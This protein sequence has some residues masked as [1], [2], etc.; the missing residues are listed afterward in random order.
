MK[1]SKLQKLPIDQVIPNPR[2]DNIHPQSQIDLMVESIR[3]FGQPRPVLVRA[4]N[5]MLIAGHGVHQ[6]MRQAGE[7]EIV[8]MIWDVD[9]RTADKFLVADNRFSELSRRDQD[10]RRDLLNEFDQEEFASLGF[11]VGEVEKMI[12]GPEAIRVIEI[13]TGPI[14]DTFWI[15]IRGPVEQQAFALKRIGELMSDLPGVEVELG[16]VAG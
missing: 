4:D 14:N 2:N 7:R 6:A 13:E 8:A 10:K 5:S 16:T 3:A 15:A 12:D 9:Q 11:L 1:T